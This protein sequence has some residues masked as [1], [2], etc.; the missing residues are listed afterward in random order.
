MNETT[1]RKILQAIARERGVS[2]AYLMRSGGL[3]MVASDHQRL[4][5]E[6]AERIAT[7][8]RLTAAE[9]Q[10]LAG[11]TASHKRS[12]LAERRRRYI[13]GTRGVAKILGISHETVARIEAGKAHDT[14]SAR[15]YFAWLEGMEARL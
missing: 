1:P 3:P 7:A 15:R 5:T 2:Y 14:E 6:V 12:E 11:V 4:S 9:R 10:Q 8:L 13:G